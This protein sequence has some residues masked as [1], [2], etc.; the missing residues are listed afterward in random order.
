MS[1]FIACFV[2][3]GSA[4][5]FIKAQEQLTLQLPHE[6][7]ETLNQTDIANHSLAPTLP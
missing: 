3:N 5:L 1:N 6:S 2:T 7:K 4:K